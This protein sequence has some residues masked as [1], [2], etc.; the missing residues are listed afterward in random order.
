MKFNV[1]A[2]KKV[3]SEAGHVVSEGEH[4]LAQDMQ[5]LVTWARL[6]FSLSEQMIRYGMAYPSVLPKDFPGHPDAPV[7]PQ[8]ADVAPVEA[9]QEVPQPAVE[10]PQTVET[11][12]AETV[13]EPAAEESV[14]AEQEAEQKPAE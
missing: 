4:M 9:P 13:V 2:I 6:R 5:E 7:V 10:A 8:Q 1:A 11:Q 12:A 3:L 14:H